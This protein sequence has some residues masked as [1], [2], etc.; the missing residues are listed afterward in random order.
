VISLIKEPFLERISSAFSEFEFQADLIIVVI[1]LLA[2][3]ATIYVPYLNATPLRY[4][5]TIPVVLF[6]PGYSLIAALFPREG[7]LSL[8]ERIALSFGLSFVIIPLIGLVLNFTPWGIRL[9]PILISLTIFTLVMVLIAFFR[10]ALLLPEARFRLPFSAIAGII[11]KGIFPADGSRIDKVLSVVL[12]LFIIVA[13]ITTF[14][15]ITF[16]KEG[17][18][19]SEFYIL[20]ENL[21]ATNYPDAIIAGLEYP[22]FIGVVNHEY[23]N[24]NYTIETWAMH[25]ELNNVTNTSPILA[26]DPLDRQSLVLSHNETLVIPYNL[27]V[28]NTSYNRVEFL[29]FNE[30]IPVPD[31]QGNDR[32]NASYRDLN[33]WITVR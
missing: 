11:H 30:T 1:W 6:I 18:K 3:F 8:L 14:Y 32:I 4:V 27:S 21:T 17:E 2:S 29:L 26:M 15:V 25:T 24:I 7:D 23:R 33:L 13:I 22:M 16:P 31:V 20:G 10:R 28:K 12:V 19:F 5:F 9:E